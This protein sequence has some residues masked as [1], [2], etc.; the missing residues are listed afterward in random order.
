MATNVDSCT[1][2]GQCSV[3]EGKTGMVKTGYVTNASV[4]AGRV[5]IGGIYYTTII[6]FKTPNFPVAA[7]EYLKFTIRIHSYNPTGIVDLRYAVCT[8]DKNYSSYYNVYGE[9]SD[10]NQLETG[11][12]TWNSSTGVYY[13][14]TVNNRKFKANTEYYLFLW[15]ATSDENNHVTLNTA[16]WTSQYAPGHVIELGY[17]RGIVYIDNGAE[18]SYYQCYIDNGSGW[19]VYIPYID[20][21]TTWDL[22]S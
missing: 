16:G 20:N 6:K 12:V 8:S 9:V 17:N 18:L 2:L 3:Y 15:S 1:V 4:N 14:L 19:D 10:S 7:S 13:E 11:V 5:N 22:C 21:G